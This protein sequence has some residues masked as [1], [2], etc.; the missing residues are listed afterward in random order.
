MKRVFDFYFI[1]LVNIDAVKYGCTVSNLTGSIL[2][3]SWANPHKYYQ[4]EIFFLK[5]FLK[6][7]NKES[8]ISLI[9]NLTAEK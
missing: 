7:I 2:N 1:P 9:I 6:E 3:K 4:S 5:E 8:P